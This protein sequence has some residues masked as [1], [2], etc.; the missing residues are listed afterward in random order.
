[1]VIQNSD[2]PQ[3]LHAIWKV[4]AGENRADNFWRSGNL[5]AYLDA[6][7]GRIHRVVRGVGPEQELLSDHPDS[8]RLMVGEHLPDWRLAT[9]LCLQASSFLPELRWQAWDVALCDR[10]PVL[11]EMN[12]GGDFNLP[13]VASGQGMMS[14]RFRAF[15]DECRSQQGGYWARRSRRKL[16][17]RFSP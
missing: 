14:D 12:I 2:G 10:G 7:D 1:M 17:A 3:I 6:A 8:G 16:A 11:L 15:L 9:E 5:L 13:Q 4:P